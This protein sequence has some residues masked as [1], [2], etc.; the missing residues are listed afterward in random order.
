MGKADR[1]LERWGDMRPDM[2]DLR[3]RRHGGTNAIICM[4]VKYV[5]ELL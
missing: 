4:E 2:D 5:S 3:I 1:P